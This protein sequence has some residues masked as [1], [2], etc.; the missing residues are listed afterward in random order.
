MTG[1]NQTVAASE[2]TGTLTF[3]AGAGLPAGLT[4]NPAGVLSGTPATVGSYNF[5]VTV[6]DS[7]GATA[8]R[9][10]TVVIAP[11]VAITTSS[12]ATW[13]ANLGGY[14][15]TIGASGGTGPLVFV[16]TSTLPSGLTLSSSGVLSGTPTTAGS[17]SV[18]VTAFDT[19]GAA[20]SH[21]F[22]VVISPAPTITTPSLAT[23]TAD[24][25]GYSQTVNAT[26]GS[27]TL[28]LHQTGS[29]PAGLTF[30]ST[31]VLSGTPTTSGTFNLMIAA[32][33]GLGATT[34]RSYT[35]TISP[36]IVITT[37]SL[38]NWTTAHAGYLQTILA[39][40]G[41]GTLTFSET[42]TLPAGLT[43]GSSGVLSGTPAGTGTYAFTVVATDSLGAKGSKGYSVSINPALAIS[44]TSLPAAM[45]GNAY[46][47]SITATGGTLPYSILT[48]TGFSAGGTGLA[49]S[50]ISANPATGVVTINGTP[51]GVGTVMFTVNATDAVGATLSQTYSL[52]V[53]T[54]PMAGFVISVPAVAAA[55]GFFNFTVT[56][57]NS[58]NQPITGY[59]GTVHFTSSD[60]AAILPTNT[61]LTGGTGTFTATLV[62]PGS[63]TIKVADLANPALNTTSTA[64]QVTSPTAVVVSPSF[65]GAPGSMTGDGHTIGFDA[66]ATIQQAL[67][68]VAAGGSVFVGA[69]SYHESLT[70]SKSVTLAATGSTSAM[71]IGPG[72]GTGLT[73]TGPHVN[74]SGLTVE[75]FG[76]GL[77]AANPTTSLVMS[78]LSLQNNTAG[79]SITNVNSVAFI[80]T[81]GDETLLASAT[82]FGRSGDNL[83]TFSD[84]G[85]LALDGN[86]G[87]NTLDLSTA[88]G[89]V[90]VA[91]FGTGSLEG[92]AGTVSIPGVI[93]T[94]VTRLV[95][96]STAG[97]SL[98]GLNAPATWSVN[99]ASMSQYG[100]GGQTLSFTSFPV[101]NG[102]TG[103]DT[104][105]VN[106]SPA[107]GLTINGQGGGDSFQ[108]PLAGLAGPV[109]LNESGSGVNAATL[110]GAGGN[111]SLT[112]TAN[113][114]TLTGGGT[115]TYAGLTKLALNAGAGADTI[116]VQGTAA[117]TT[118]TISGTGTDTFVVTSPSG[119]LN[120]IAGPLSLNGGTGKNYLYLSEANR[121]TPD[122]V[123]V[124]DTAIISGTGTFAPISYAATG[125]NFGSGVILI[126]GNA[127]NTLRVFSTAAGDAYGL[128]TGNG[129]SS[130]VI[131]SATQTLSTMAGSI[132]VVA[133]SGSNMLYVSE[134]GSSTPD[135]LSLSATGIQSTAANFAV[136]YVA[137]GGTF[138]HGVYLVTG[139]GNNN[140]RIY[141]TAAG[142]TNGIELGNGNNN[143]VV[144]S[145][146]QTLSTMAGPIGVQGGT[147]VNQLYVSEAGS[148]VP[149]SIFVSGVSV[150]SPTLG[151][152]ISYTA[153]PGGSFGRG[154][155]VVGGSGGSHVYVVGQLAGSPI[156]IYSGS[157]NDVIE[158]FVSAMS[159]YNLWLNG[160]GGTNHLYV[161][162]LAGSAMISAVAGVIQLN[163]PGGLPSTIRYSNL[164]F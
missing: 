79:G 157:G 127:D 53:Q 97:S 142:S 39:S 55:N 52:T 71:L 68:V 93:F 113:S 50:A 19:V 115:V 21:T 117:G 163:Y 23:W 128:Y 152:F 112:V 67:N 96:N 147:G 77:S 83:L 108:V 86:G 161:H 31:G 125:G 85:S 56:A 1:Y 47:Q 48:V 42:G 16:A 162:D 148:T 57:V 59:N 160:Q 20:G 18:S 123:Y 32:T 5:T 3:S 145:P 63:Q 121:T 34:S 87:N 80:G 120:T 133:G 13:T 137:P 27:D 139:N 159:F 65:S 12:V 150:Q 17:Y 73:I 33:D 7:V 146:T 22:T 107:S 104:F 155:D 134:A 46:M 81:G 156:G 94:N 60:G 141:S 101:L 130:I 116:A 15:Q 74:V 138:G 153:A 37:A 43:L 99:G 82:H 51:T 8:N 119:L 95:G 84:V 144:S 40:G 58:S 38:P 62:T 143:V 129:N 45:V 149:D 110:T 88:S 106:G 164:L 135:S 25:S 103:S 66:F 124:T 102:G 30:S 35:L 122:T 154:V 26:G 91:L 70:V 11:A 44:P 72:S 61:M 100:S 78:D 76:T 109:A 131:S 24:L 64:I 90:G 14:N 29:L 49:A 126:M 75:N 151:Y 69:A 136:S 2:G 4:L 9:S 54:V 111:S 132:A 158:A 114:V 92:F 10:Y 140:V 6:T 28:T 118:T 89:P 41:T 98:S 105:M 36:A